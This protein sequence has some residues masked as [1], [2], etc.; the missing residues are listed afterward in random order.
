MEPSA[1]SL[2]EKAVSFPA[3]PGI[4]GMFEFGLPIR[5]AGENIKL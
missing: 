4:T 5:T 3:G 1:A 2:T